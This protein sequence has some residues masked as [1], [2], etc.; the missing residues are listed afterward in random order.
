[1]LNSFCFGTVRNETGKNE[2]DKELPKGKN[3]S[4]EKI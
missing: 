4:Q 2:Y 1:M 3:V